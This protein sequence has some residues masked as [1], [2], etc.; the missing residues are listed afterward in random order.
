MFPKVIKYLNPTALHISRYTMANTSYELQTLPSGGQSQSLLRSE[1][2]EEVP[3]TPNND[4]L[5][6]PSR[7]ISQSPLPTVKP[8][9]MLDKLFSAAL[10]ARSCL[11]PLVACTYLAFC[12]TVHTK[13]VPLKSSLFNTT[14]DNLGV[15]KSGVTSISIIIITIGLFP[16]HVLISDLRSE[17][18]FRVVLDRPA[19]APLYSVN[20]IS[21]SSFGL[22]ESLMV[23]VRRH[24]SPYFITAVITTLLSFVLATLAPAGLSVTTAYFDGEL[25]AMSIGAIHRDD[26]MNFTA[27]FSQFADLTVS[28][29]LFSQAAAVA[30]IENNL[31]LPY[32]FE[33]SNG[34]NYVVPTP[35]NLRRDVATRWL[36][37]VAILKPVCEWPQESPLSQRIDRNTP[38]EI[39]FGFT[40]QDLNTTEFLDSLSDSNSI[41][42][43][44]QDWS[45][46]RDT[47][48]DS[49]VSSGMVAWTVGR[50]RAGCFDVDKQVDIDLTG[51]PVVTVIQPNFNESEPDSI[52]DVAFLHCYPNT[53]IETREV[54]HDGHGTLTVLDASYPHQHNLHPTQTNILLSNLLKL[55]Y[56]AGGPSLGN[57]VS[58]L[59]T[60]A[61][62]SLF[63]GLNPINMSALG[64]RAFDA[65]PQILSLA[66]IENITATYARMLHSAS[67]I[68]LDGTV[69]RHYVPARLLTEQVVFSASLPQVIVSTVLF[70]LLCVVAVVSHFRRQRPKFTLFN[71]AV[72]LQG[73]DIPKI[74]SQVRD[75]AGREASES[76]MVATLGGRVVVASGG[77]GGALHLR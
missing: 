37:D 68:L 60:Q 38:P 50:C 4:T 1:E 30:W 28:D 17:E 70:V 2:C 19:G 64:Q 3:G 23:M 35:L 13:S 66:P 53:V 26:I 63:F 67:K 21:N 34:P 5:L 14:P 36:S 32:S 24:C 16:I 44:T 51:I 22:I 15:I 40:A 33:V 45:S 72:S 46:V 7:R 41:N 47:S 74:M 12:Y 10:I 11:L 59:G 73:S 27:Q 76:D 6:I 49:L 69:S 18:F 29:E 43:W 57:A 31:G 58:E 20:G 56:T 42:L 9:R 65:P 61:Q 55:L 52:F 39:S 75:D 77:D 48:S 8:K 54:R 62:V 25:V 71:V